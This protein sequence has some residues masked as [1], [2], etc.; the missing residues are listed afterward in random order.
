M[1]RTI[2]L[3]LLITLWVCGLTITAVNARRVVAYKK[4]NNDL[5]NTRKYRRRLH[6][7]LGMMGDGRDENLGIGTALPRTDS[8]LEDPTLAPSSDIGRSA[9]GVSASDR[10]QAPVDPALN[11]SAC[12]D[13]PQSYEV[14]VDLQI[15]FTEGILAACAENEEDQITAAITSA[16]NDAFPTTVPDWN[17]QAVFGPFA[18]DIAQEI[19]NTDPFAGRTRRFLRS[20]AGPV[21]AVERSL[22]QGGNCPDRSVDCAADYCRWGCLSASTTNCA[23]SSLIN[24]ANLADDVRKRLVRLGF[25]CLGIPDELDV[26]V[27]LGDGATNNG[28]SP[29]SLGRDANAVLTNSQPHGRTENDSPFKIFTLKSHLGFTFV[30]GQGNAPTDADVEALVEETK[31]FFTGVFSNYDEMNFVLFNMEQLKSSYG[32]NKTSDKFELDFIAEVVM[33]RTTEKTLREMAKKM[34][35]ANYN[36][37]IENYVRN[38]EPFQRNQFYKTNSVFFKA[39]GSGS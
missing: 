11:A 9:G 35:G 14:N 13:N 34:S 17:G 18:F 6:R 36:E 25:D 38:S 21:D 2:Y 10:T 7:R 32:A 15:N 22:Q 20:V 16:M 31:K 5:P 27:I 39:V 30:T 29:A 1:T 23:T 26:I 4:G 12:M 24:W 37:Y 8:P 3:I 28:G 19:N 33:Q